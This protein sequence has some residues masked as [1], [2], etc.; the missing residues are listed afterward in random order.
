MPERLEVGEYPPT[1]YRHCSSDK[2]RESSFCRLGDVEERV[3]SKHDDERAD[4]DRPVSEEHRNEPEQL[5]QL[6]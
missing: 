1:P 2:A 4:S 6:V 5:E 3:D